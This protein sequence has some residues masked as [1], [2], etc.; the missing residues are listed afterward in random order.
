MPRQ[1]GQHPLRKGIRPHGKLAACR[2]GHKPGGRFDRRQQVP[3]NH[4]MN[5]PKLAF[6][7]GPADAKRHWMPDGRLFVLE[8]LAFARVGAPSDQAGK[9]VGSDECDGK[10]LQ[11]PMKPG[12]MLHRLAEDFNQVVSCG[13]HGGVGSGLGEHLAE[14]LAGGGHALVL[15]RNL[16]LS[17]Q[18]LIER[19][20]GGLESL[21][22]FG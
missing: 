6:L 12:G 14:D 7:L 4:G 10:R 11:L 16:D 17:R 8:R 15:I 9:L 3:P 22:P 21:D 18:H 5:L 13:V 2:V 20:Q 19:Y 1:F